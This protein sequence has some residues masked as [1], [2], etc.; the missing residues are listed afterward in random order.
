MELDREQIMKALECCEGGGKPC[1]SCPY[2]YRAVDTSCAPFLIKDA[3]SLIKELTEEVERLEK[4]KYVFATVDYCADDLANA[5]EENK[6]LTAENES[7]KQCM[8]HEHASFM[9]TFGE[10]GEKCERL[11]EEKEELTIELNAMRTAANSYKMHYEKLE[12]ENERL[13]ADKK[14]L[15]N[16]NAELKNQLKEEIV[17]EDT[18]LSDELL[19]LH[20]EGIKEAKAYTV[21]KMQ[22]EIKKRCIEGGIYPALVAR[23]ID[24]V[25]KEM[26]NDG[27]EM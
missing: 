20:I 6:R 14:E 15:I 4:A 22:E 23:T 11:A 18:D 13:K 27:C 24:K 25:A 2:F 26:L 5:L 10:Y 17:G 8:E 21:R 16:D 7:L 3:L 1:L 19:K 9:E 12:A